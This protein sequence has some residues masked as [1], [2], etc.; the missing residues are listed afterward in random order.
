MLSDVLPDLSIPYFRF[1]PCVPAISLDETSPLK[2]RE[3]QAIGRAHVTTGAAKDDC[4]ALAQLLR[5]GDGAA[6]SR[7]LQWPAT[8][9]AKIGRGLSALHSRL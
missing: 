8:L 2:L 7:Q 9:L 6:S 5:G 4:A 3:L 1:N